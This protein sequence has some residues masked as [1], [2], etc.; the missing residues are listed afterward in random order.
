MLWL[1]IMRIHMA[2]M[3]LLRS[4]ED[5]SALW[6]LRLLLDFLKILFYFFCT[7]LPNENKQL[8]GVFPMME[9]SISLEYVI[10]DCIT[11]IP[12][13]CSQE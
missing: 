3:D 1:I 12:K 4:A 11:G 9:F 10:L 2:L 13:V 6:F 7:V 5:R 8:G